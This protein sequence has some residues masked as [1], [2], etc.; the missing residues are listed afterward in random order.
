MFRNCLLAA[1]LALSGCAD[2]PPEMHVDGEIV[3]H[4]VQHA[5]AQ[6]DRDRD[7]EEHGR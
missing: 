4:A 2:A 5:Q 3:R 1:L 6:V 7:R